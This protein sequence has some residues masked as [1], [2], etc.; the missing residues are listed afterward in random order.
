[1]YLDYSDKLVSQH[2]TQSSHPAVPAADATGFAVAPKMSPGVQLCRG[3]SVGGSVVKCPS[4]LNV[5]KY[6]YM[7]AIIAVVECVQMNIST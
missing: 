2:F 6:K 3:D 1:M 4:P 7:Y 5:L